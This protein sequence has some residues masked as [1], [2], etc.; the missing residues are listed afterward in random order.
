MAAPGQCKLSH[1]NGPKVMAD[2]ITLDQRTMNRA[3]E[4]AAGGQGCVEPNPMVGCVILSDNQIVGEGWHA[5]FGK[6]HEEVIALQE[7]GTRARGGTLY[8]TLEPCC[9]QGKTPPCIDAI[10][11]AG[12]RRV[13]IAQRDPFSAVNG[14]GQ[15]SCR[16]ICA[17][18]DDFG[19]NVVQ[20][21]G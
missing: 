16:R 8:V 11:R 17:S 15:C 12:I 2:S 21:R 10:K 14:D 19:T 1:A 18:P 7:A 6:P 4:L 9:H 5:V 3:L 20:A 13:V